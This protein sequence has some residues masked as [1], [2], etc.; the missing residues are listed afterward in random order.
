MD[1]MIYYA[2]METLCK[3]LVVEN[4]AMNSA[5]RTATKMI[6]NTTLNRSRSW[7]QSPPTFLEAADRVPVLM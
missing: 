7:L 4:V 1:N 3:S 2:I 6:T 5:D